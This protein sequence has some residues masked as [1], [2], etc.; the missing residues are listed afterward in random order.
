MIIINPPTYV[1]IK[2]ESAI[3]HYEKLDTSFLIA[4]LKDSLP[5][6]MYLNGLYKG[7]LHKV[8]PVP[9]MINKKDYFAIE[10]IIKNRPYKF[11]CGID[12]IAADNGFDIT[13]IDSSGKIKYRCYLCAYCHTKDNTSY[14]SIN[15]F[16]TLLGEI[17]E[18]DSSGE[19]GKRI[20]L[21]IDDLLID[22]NLKIRN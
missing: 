6:D 20:E 2:M 5:Y 19:V 9:I 4:F 11:F 17:K 13:S 8:L 18:Y 3:I 1:E 15:Y 10:S 21:I 22:D 12:T 14:T 16:K 7:V